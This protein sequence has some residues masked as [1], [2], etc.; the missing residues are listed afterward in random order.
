MTCSEKVIAMVGGPELFS[1]SERKRVAVIEKRQ[2]R[3]HELLGGGVVPST[4]SS[5]RR[6]DRFFGIVTQVLPRDVFNQ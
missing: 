4:R 5:R 6:V 1:V 2:G 3:G